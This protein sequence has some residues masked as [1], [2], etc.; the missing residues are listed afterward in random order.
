MKEIGEYLKN[1]RLELGISL[2]DAEQFLKIRKKYLIA[3]EEGDESVLPGRTYFVGYLRNYAN[4][5]EADPE[6]I[7][8]L[9]QKTEQKPQIVEDEQISKRRKP[10]K[11]KGPEKRKY[12]IRKEKK[13]LN[14]LPLLKFAG[15]LIVI[16]GLVFVISQFLQRMNQPPVKIL[17]EEASPGD[18]LIIEE[19][20]SLEQELL[21]IAEENIQSEV[22]AEEP[23]VN[24]L[25]PLP[26]FKPIQITAVE[27]NW[28][29]IMQDDEVLF[30]SIISSS[31][32]IIIRSDGQISVLTNRSD[33]IS[34]S[35]DGQIIEPQPSDK[36]PLVVYQ[37][38]PV[39][40]N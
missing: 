7:D 22:I 29:K 33:S 11:Y 40:N 10:G 5:L 25:E 39:N 15:M 26:D 12:R 6:S 38:I 35:Y 24:L 21:E 13:P 17:E 9:L 28:I 30:E 16:A 32:E 37:I 36:D 14:F 19:E 31:E 1:R 3:I 20:K 34:V 18:A 23:V 4:Y 8:Q 27:P 2:E